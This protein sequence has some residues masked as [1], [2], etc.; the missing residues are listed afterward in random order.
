MLGGTIHQYE[1][2][3][4]STI[5]SVDRELCIGDVVRLNPD[6]AA[7]GVVIDVRARANLRSPQKWQTLASNTIYDVLISDLVDSKDLDL[8]HII[9]L[10]GW[11]GKSQS[12]IAVI[13][14]T[15]ATQSLEYLSLSFAY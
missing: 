1:L 15:L 2:I 9:Y 14:V 4:E 13:F 5:E 6:D 8:D 12:A 3:P 11:I 7:S 10:D